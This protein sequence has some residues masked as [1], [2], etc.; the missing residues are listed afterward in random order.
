M[1]TTPP[2]VHR[3]RPRRTAPHRS[4]GV[5]TPPVPSAVI[6]P[7]TVF[8]TVEL[9][10]VRERLTAGDWLQEQLASIGGD[11]ARDSRLPLPPGL[12]ASG[13]LRRHRASVVAVILYLVLVVI[14]GMVISL[15][16]EQL[17]ATPFVKLTDWRELPGAL[18]LYLVLAPVLWTFYLWQPRL[19][20]EVFDGLAR[21]GAIG[22]PRR[23][24]ITP[25]ALLRRIGGSLVA[26]SRPIG[27]R[28][29][30]KGTLLAMLSLLAAIATL[31][32]WPPTALPPF[33]RL[34]PASDLFWWR[35]IPVY[36][37]FVWLPLVFVNVYMLVWIVIRQT[38]MIANIQRLLRL[39][40][41]QPI[42]FHPDG[43]SGFAPIGS[44]AVTIVRVALVI[45]G[46]AL[47]LLLS[48][49]ISGHG[50]YLASATLFLVVVQVLLTPYL[51]L[52]PVWYAHRVMRDARQRAL[53]RVGDA[54]RCQLLAEASGPGA[55][56]VPQT[57]PLHQLEAR[58]RLVE[59]GYETWPFGRTAWSRVSITAGL[60]LLANIAAIL[61]RIYG[62]P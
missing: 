7:T 10:G 31:L 32:V 12:T 4:N 44:Y 50:L 62:T 17:T 11:E 3:R 57:E 5:G 25:D 29:V 8:S 39:F 58:Y 60:T 54:I 21:S 45:G 23:T 18:F 51:L 14:P 19:I 2:P 28:R 52:G 27:G 30:V 26:T 59:E 15:R 49:P 40:D 20:V 48:G 43:C 34:L 33:D 56:P 1:K 42:P 46:W 22:P 61:Y 24:D 41:V 35:V 38:I 36:F 16:G 53:Q 9:Q 6:E 13:F 55:S 47:I 37:W